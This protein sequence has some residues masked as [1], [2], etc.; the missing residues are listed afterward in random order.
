MTCT[1][2][3]GFL[4]LTLKD[5]ESLYRTFQYKSDD[6]PVNITG[7]SFKMHIKESG[8]ALA[9]DAS[10]FITI[11]DAVNGKFE[12]NIP[13]ATIAANLTTGTSYDYSMLYISSGGIHKELFTGTVLVSDGI[14]DA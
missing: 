7:A 1:T 13:Q 3:A 5:N 4:A 12:L 14:T 10:S 11:T 9:L 6:V 8:G 2:Q